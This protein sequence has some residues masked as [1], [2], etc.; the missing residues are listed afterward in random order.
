MSFASSGPAAHL[1]GRSLGKGLKDGLSQRDWPPQSALHQLCGLSKASLTS[2]S[3]CFLSCKA[4]ICG[5][6]RAEINIRSA[7]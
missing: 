7:L 3:L 1:G 5:W 2:L 4:T 6:P